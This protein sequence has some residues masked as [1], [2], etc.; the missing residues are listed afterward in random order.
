M[1][2]NKRN[3]RVL[4][5]IVAFAVVLFSMVQNFEMVM[6][7]VRGVL[8][9]FSPVII[10]FCIAFVLNVLLRVLEERVFAF[11]DK[12][13]P[14]RR[15]IKRPIS[16]LVTILVAFGVI[17]I[18]LLVILPELQDTILRLVNNLPGYIQEASAWL[19]GWLIRFNLNTDFLHNTKIDWNQVTAAV[20]SMFNANNTSELVGTAAGMTASVFSALTSFLFGFIIAIYV[21]AEKEKI[22]KMMHRIIDL[23]FSKATAGRIVRVCRV[24]YNSFT[25]FVTGQLVEAVI[26]SLLC[27]VGMLIFQLPSAGIISALIGVT[28]LVPIVGALVGETVGCLLILMVSPLKALLF[29]VFILSLQLVEGN[30]IYPKVVG[31]SVGLPG[32]IVLIAVIVGG[33]L[34]GILGVLLG[35][36]ISSVLYTLLLDW[37]DR[38]ERAA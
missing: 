38:R 18:L 23:V 17:T 28:A 3:V 33:N 30:F 14:W 25:N 35:V 5:G 4:L 10:G 1:E 21:L 29:L 22:A 32:I 37:M 36:P 13:P 26:L 9:I 15:K 31:K 6:G 11:L 34:G 12:G 27:F 19:E 2:F 8:S 24:A 16:L 20:Q 7:F